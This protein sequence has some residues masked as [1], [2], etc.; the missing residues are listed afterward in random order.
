[1]DTFRPSVPSSS[2]SW[3]SVDDACSL[4]L[5]CLILKV[6]L[7][8]LKRFYGNGSLPV[9]LYRHYLCIGFFFT[10]SITGNVFKSCVG[11][12]SYFKIIK[13]TFYGKWCLKYH[14]WVKLQ[15]RTD[16]PTTTVAHT[17]QYYS[18]LLTS[19][20]HTWWRPSPRIGQATAN[21]TAPVK[22]LYWYQFYT[23]L[24]WR[25]R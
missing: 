4:K 23:S 1:M 17:K 8:T 24:V 7:W 25:G 15:T 20:P 10:R 2:N 18:S 3:F 14:S 6:R 12:T 16:P 21:F 5:I 9:D 22:V 13:I 11:R 19:T